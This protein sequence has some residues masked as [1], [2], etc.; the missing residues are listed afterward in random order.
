VTSLTSNSHSNGFDTA[1]QFS[2]SDVL[3]TVEAICA[4]GELGRSGRLNDLLRYV[5]AEELEGRGHRT[6]A[7]SIATQALGRGVDFDPAHDSIVRVE[8][9]RL[10]TVLKLF[11]SGNTPV[12]VIIDIPKGGYRPVIKR[13]PRAPEP[14]ASPAAEPV[15][16]P[17]ARRRD[18]PKPL[19]RTFAVGWVFF[20]AAA[21]VIAVLLGLAYRFLS[22]QAVELVRLPPV[23][24]VSPIIISSPN[25]AMKAFEDGLKGELVAEMSRY[26]WV[27]VA[28]RSESPPVAEMLQQ[29]SVY[30]V[31]MKL[32]IESAEFSSVTTLADAATGRVRWSHATRGLI[33]SD[34]IFPTLAAMVRLVGS[35]VSQP[36]GPVTRAELDGIPP[37]DHGSYACLLLARE[38]VLSVSLD[39]RARFQACVLGQTRPLDALGHAFAAFALLDRARVEGG[40]SRSLQMSAAA[41]EIKRAID[42]RSRHY[43][44][45]STAAQLRTCRGDRPGME[46]HFAEI[47]AARPND[48]VAVL[49]LAAQRAF[50]FGDLES[51]VL[52]A[53][54]RQNNSPIPFLSPSLIIGLSHLM[55]GDAVKAALAL[56]AGPANPHPVALALR[57]AAYGELGSAAALKAMFASLPVG[58]ISNMEELRTYVANE[59]LG[60]NVRKVLNV[61]LDKAMMLR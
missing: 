18:D 20:L 49:D 60:D 14:P 27:A 44:V 40:P 17:Q 10:R 48:P 35:E 42:M 37:T 12:P 7:Y 6:K 38:Y 45:L 23:V 58:L 4:S 53:S 15:V 11:Y 30:A 22:I 19:K 52:A 8:M 21:S 55:R 54:N 26:P 47:L 43:L 51:A 32:V 57:T 31:S 41:E 34:T 3:Q 25:P 16:E 13:A 2:T 24:M 36:F 33:A 46:A 29:R 5:V 50:G 9:A 59:C 1:A 56:D 28:Y 39:S 61:G